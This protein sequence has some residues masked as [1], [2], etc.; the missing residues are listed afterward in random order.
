MRWHGL[1]FARGR[2]TAGNAA[3]ERT[4][5]DLFLD[6]VDGS[7]DALGHRPG[8]LG[9]DRD[10]EVAADVAEQRP[11][12]LRKV[13][14]IGGEALHRRLAGDEHLAAVFE[15]RSRVDVGVDQVS[16]RAVNRP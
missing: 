7:A 4:G 1:P 5:L 9:L 14:R 15:L 13:M 16:D 12:G 3:V 11:V 8:D 2:A 6:E 10:R